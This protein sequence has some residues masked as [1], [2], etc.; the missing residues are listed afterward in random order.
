MSKQ[1]GLPETLGLSDNVTTFTLSEFGRTL[2]INGTGTDHG[3]GGHH[4]VTGGAVTGGNLIGE[5][6]SLEPG[7][8]DDAGEGRIIPTTSFDSFTAEL[9]RWFG[10]SQ[11]DLEQL[12]PNSINFTTPLGLFT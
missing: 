10:L 5:M 1:T 2:T 9:C 8:D 12:L 7:S 6:P 3:W 4:F 11:E